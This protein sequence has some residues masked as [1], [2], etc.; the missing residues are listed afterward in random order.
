MGD[1]DNI[2]EYINDTL[3]SSVGLGNEES[4]RIF[5]EQPVRREED[6]LMKMEIFL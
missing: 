6:W 1:K 3:V 4:I 2:F 5:C